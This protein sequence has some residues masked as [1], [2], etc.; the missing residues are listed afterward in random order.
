MRSLRISA[1]AQAQLREI[2]AY[3]VRE[4]GH[5]GLADAFRR[6]LVQKGRR[7][8]SLPGTLGT[9]RTDLGPDIRSTPVANYILIFRYTADT[10]DVLAV[11]H[12]SRD[13]IAHFEAG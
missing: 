9:A 4:S 13:T 7:L 1:R 8:A 2:S 11:L 10:V 5:R 6:R 3:I 12:A